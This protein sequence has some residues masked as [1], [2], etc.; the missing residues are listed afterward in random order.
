MPYLDSTGGG[1]MKL[2]PEQ[3][4]PTLIISL[5]FM[6]SIVYL[7]KGDFRGFAYSISAAVLNVAVTF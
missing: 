2:K 4:F 3:I 6:S 5:F 1:E 7:F